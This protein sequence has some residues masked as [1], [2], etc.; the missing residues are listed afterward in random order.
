MVKNL[1]PLLLI[2]ELVEKLK[3][4]QWFT[5]LDVRWGYRNVW[6]KDGDEW[7]AAFQ[8]NHRLF[9][10][11]VMMFRLTNAPATV[12]TLIRMERRMES[13]TDKEI[14]SYIY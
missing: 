1:Y 2:S 7:K 11:L 10:P 13:G 9:K 14:L 8:T 4:A 6:M 12:T 5:K 3:G